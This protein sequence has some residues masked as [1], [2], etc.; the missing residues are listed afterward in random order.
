MPL[1]VRRAIEVAN[2][3]LGGTA[4]A[5]MA[6]RQL[7][8][9]AGQL[10]EGAYEWRY[11][12]RTTQS[13][14]Y[15]PQFS[16]SLATYDETAKT[17]TLVG[18]WSAYTF[19]PGDTLSV[20]LSGTSFGTYRVSAKVSDDVLTIDSDLTGV[21]LLPIIDFTMDTGRVALPSD[22]GRLIRLE[23]KDSFL[24]RAYPSN[25]SDIQRLQTSATPGNGYRIAYAVEYNS[26]TPTS[27]PVPTLRLWPTPDITDFEALGATYSREWPDLTSDDDYIP[28]PPYM[29]PLFLQYARVVATGCDGGEDATRAATL[30]MD[31]TDRI[32][33]SRMFADATGRDVATHPDAGLVMGGAMRPSRIS[34][35]YDPLDVGNDAFLFASE[36]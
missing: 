14:A 28:I 8:T 36:A 27:Q 30:M 6:G 31:L 11:L 25:T 23:G 9:T 21:P 4:P 2:D 17:L 16:G 12:R 1:T 18:A 7:L 15:R 3:T 26:A 35:G 19:V 20:T 34:G 33:G 5:A 13:I 29:E 32:R 22:F 24:T 10:M